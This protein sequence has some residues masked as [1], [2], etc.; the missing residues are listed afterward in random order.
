MASTEQSTA[1]RDGWVMGVTFAAFLAMFAA[2]LAAGFAWRAFD[3]SNEA[4][5]V[6]GSGRMVVEVEMGEMFVRPASIEVPAGTQLILAVHNAGT[7]EHDLKLNGV[8]GTDLLQPGARQEVA[9]GVQESSGEAWCTV[10]GH[11]AAGMEMKIVVT[12]GA[13]AANQV[14]ANPDGV[15]AVSADG[16]PFAAVEA[17]AEPAPGWVSRDPVAPPTPEGTLHEIELHATEEL[18][19]VAPGVTQM[20]WTF[21]S[22]VPGPIIRAS[23]GDTVKVTLYNDGEVGHSI[24]FHA[25]KVAW[26]DEMR[27]ILPG[28]SLVYEWE[29]KH[30]GIF[31]YHCGTPPTLHHIGNGMYGAVIVDPPDLAPVDEEFVFVQSEMYFGPLNGVGD[32]GKMQ[33]DE[34]DAV[35]FN[36]YFNQYFYDPIQVEPDE[37]IRVWVMDDGPSE[38]SAFHIVGTI[39]DTVYKEG[40]YLL[41]PDSGLSG[42]SQVLD[43]QPAQGGFVEFTLDEAGLYPIVTHKFS[44]VGKGALG[45][46]QAG[47]VELP[48]SMGH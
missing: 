28:E 15:T 4:A 2:V 48:E 42:G 22:Q 35:T 33:R 34:W 5:S 29:I 26:N 23:I 47:D 20:M 13:A 27:T 32:L 39:F 3:E 38:N 21:N 36:G 43:L 6:A 31:M 17:G 14:A 1:T 46:F 44:N 41:R 19:E 25:S 7:L 10:E 11:R 12:G 9:L 30:S 40:E 24:D 18:L 8:T 37:R 16:Q 45:I